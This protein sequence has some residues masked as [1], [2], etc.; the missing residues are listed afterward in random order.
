LPSACDLTG[1]FCVR[2]SI[3]AVAFAYSGALAVA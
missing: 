2:I 3:V 1:A